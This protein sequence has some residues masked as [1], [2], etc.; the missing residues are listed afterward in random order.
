MRKNGKTLASLLTASCV[1]VVAG[2]G[3]SPPPVDSSNTEATVK[4]MI[5]VNGA[6]SGEGEVTFDPANIDR[7]D[8]KPR[9]AVV[10]KDGTFTITTLT[11]ANQ[12]T[13]KGSFVKKHPILEHTSKEVV[14]KS[15]ENTVNLE[16]TADK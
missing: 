6:P 15:G 9:T 3:D 1:W 10:G 12:V 11:G 8:A 13:L 2:C 16:Y 4:G 7:K 14:V 5:K